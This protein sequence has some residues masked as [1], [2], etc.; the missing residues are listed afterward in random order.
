MSYRTFSLQVVEIIYLKFEIILFGLDISI[1]DDVREVL[2]FPRQ[3]VIQKTDIGLV[4]AMDLSV[5]EK[6]S[7]Y[8]EEWAP[9]SSNL[10]KKCNKNFKTNYERD[11]LLIHYVKNKRSKHCRFDDG[12]GSSTS[13]GK[14]E[15]ASGFMS[16]GMM[17]SGHR[18]DVQ[19][20]LREIVA[21]SSI[22]QLNTEVAQGFKEENQHPEPQ[23]LYSL[24]DAVEM[25]I[26]WPPLKH[27][28]P[29]FPILEK[30]ADIIQKNLE[31]RTLTLVHLSK[32]HV[33]LCMHGK[34]PENIFCFVS[35]LRS[36]SL[37][38]PP[39]VI[40]HPHKP[41]AMDWGCVGMFD[42]V[43]FLQG[44]PIHEIDLMRAGVLQAG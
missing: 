27:E 35:H 22:E 23:K 31:E 7:T 36:P 2:L 12:S 10:Y 42:D 16:Y 33:L 1:D 39:I 25:I 17:K 38:N 34:W 20:Q 18:A 28:K 43:Y 29:D 13:M 41:T 6:V 5:A 4:I 3:R 11:D 21:T 30:R 9:W 8:C 15:R 40:I 24:Q 32:P 44:S 14:R 26:Q 19:T 37:P